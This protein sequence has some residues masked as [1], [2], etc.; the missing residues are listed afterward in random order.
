MNIDMHSHII[1]SRFVK[2]IQGSMQFQANLVLKDGKEFIAH[3]QGYVYPYLKEFFDPEAKLADMDKRGIDIT[4]LSTAPPL[5][6]YWSEP[7]LAE[8]V[9]QMVNDETASLVKDYPNRFLAMATVPMNDVERATKELERAVT[10]L[11]MRAVEI[12]SNIEGKLLNEPQFS[13]FFQKAEELD[14]L[15][16]VHPYYIGHKQNLENYYLTNF[17]GNPLDTTVTM[18]NLIFSGFMERFQNLN[19]CFAHGGG[20]FPYQIGRFEHGYH[21]RPEPKEKGSHPPL[22]TLK[23]FYFDTITFHPKSLDFL[24]DLVGSGK[25]LMGSDFPFD[26]GDPDPVGSVNALSVAEREKEKILGK[27]VLGLFKINIANT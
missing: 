15:V 7:E 25:V 8:Y 24:V 1:P 27:N 9:A 6:Y 11:G 5:F 4:V 26:M 16:F 14:V 3:D 2:E 18:A 12:G 10:K 17:I 19:L 22:E 21:V 13:S 23:R 20:F